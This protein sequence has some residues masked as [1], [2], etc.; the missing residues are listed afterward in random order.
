MIITS[1]N[2]IFYVFNYILLDKHKGPTWKVPL[3]HH[4]Y[5]IIISWHRKKGN[6]VWGW[7][8]E[9]DGGSRRCDQ[10]TVYSCTY[11]YRNNRQQVLYCLSRSLF[12]CNFINTRHARLGL[13]VVLSNEYFVTLPVFINLLAVLSVG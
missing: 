9:R 1:R 8:E 11:T 2:M 13:N 6:V 5:W 10:C 7:R 12:L 4:L 3:S